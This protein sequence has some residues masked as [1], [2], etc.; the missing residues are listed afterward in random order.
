VSWTVTASAQSGPPFAKIAKGRLPGRFFV[1]K[2]VP[3]EKEAGATKD[4][5]A[6][7]VSQGY[8]LFP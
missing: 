6:R 7:E 5:R 8:R 4:R 3:R 2:D 1:I